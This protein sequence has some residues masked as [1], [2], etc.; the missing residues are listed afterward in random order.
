MPDPDFVPAQPASW[1]VAVASAVIGVLAAGW[2]LLSWQV[3]H[4]D[5]GDALGE[6]LGAGLGLLVAVSIVGAILSARTKGG[7]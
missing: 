1:R 2:F 5:V 7:R 4:T 3:I 6:A